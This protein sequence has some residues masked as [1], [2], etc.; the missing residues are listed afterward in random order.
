M[1]ALSVT[2]LIFVTLIGCV[3]RDGRNSDC[4]WPAE[5]IRRFPDPRH[6]SADAEFAEDL[7]I[8]Y[9]DVHHGLRTPFYV[10]GDDYAAARDRCREALFGQI[11]TEHGVPVEYVS[12]ALGRNRG[13]IDVATYL[14][15][16]LLC[17][18]TAAAL[19]R[20]VWRK[21]PAI[22]EGWVPGTV[23]ALFLSLVFAA[24]STMT[25][26]MWSWLVETY[27]IGNHHMSYRGQRLWWGQHRIEVFI[28]A[29]IVFFLA[30]THA[31]RHTLSTRSSTPDPAL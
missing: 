8:R 29:W 22:G 26:E 31:A 23:M 15:F 20:I 18:F 7:A 1:G 27:R 28:A 4:K 12:G 19:A 17:C 6:L 13:R 5:V 10:S 14:P 9:A 21:Y 2:L 3:R 16:V 30:A 25:G 11:A 24:G